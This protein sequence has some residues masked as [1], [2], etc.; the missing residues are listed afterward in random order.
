M[1]ASL[2]VSGMHLLFAHGDAECL[3]FDGVMN[4]A[5]LQFLM[6]TGVRTVEA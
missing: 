3:Q 2:L 4:K 5:N 1:A 6:C